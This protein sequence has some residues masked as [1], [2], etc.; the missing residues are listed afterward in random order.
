MTGG[1]GSLE[2]YNFSRGYKNLQD[3]TQFENGDLISVAYRNANP[4]SRTL[5]E[6]FELLRAVRDETSI[7]FLEACNSSKRV[8][9]ETLGQDIKVKHGYPW[10][11]DLRPH[12][13]VRLKLGNR[14]IDFTTYPSD[15]GRIFLAHW[16][17]V[18]D[19][20][21]VNVV[22]ENIRNGAIFYL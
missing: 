13:Y 1:T 2:G 10:N 8:Q 7:R 3:L 4:D 21:D 11:F 9:L 20:D 19:E 15:N 12:K 17:H 14:Y 6:G 22:R 16:V 5:R 18:L